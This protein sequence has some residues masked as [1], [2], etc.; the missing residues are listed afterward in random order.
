MKTE[1]A[2]SEEGDSLFLTLGA[3]SRIDMAMLAEI[4]LALSGSPYLY[5]TEDETY[6]SKKLTPDHLIGYGKICLKI[7]IG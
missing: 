5:S 6:D 4:V 1:V 7:P 3:Q 2:L